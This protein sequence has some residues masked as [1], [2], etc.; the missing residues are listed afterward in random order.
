MIS[1][2]GLKLALPLLAAMCLLLS[3]YVVTTHDGCGGLKEDI[4]LLEAP[5]NC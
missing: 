5:H 3:L 1:Q 2:R 4:T